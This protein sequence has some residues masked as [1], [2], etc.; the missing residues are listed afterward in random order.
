MAKCIGG[1][2][3]LDGASFSGS[4]SSP[5]FRYLISRKETVL[6]VSLYSEPNSHIL[7]TYYTMHKRTER[8]KER[9]RANRTEGTCLYLTANDYEYPLHTLRPIQHHHFDIAIKFTYNGRLVELNRVPQYVI[10]PWPTQLVQH[11]NT[12]IW[13]CHRTATSIQRSEHDGIDVRRGSR[14][15][16]DWASRYV[17]A[18]IDEN[19]VETKDWGRRTSSR[20]IHRKLH[21]DR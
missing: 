12:H 18:T 7:W 2:D 20:S 5:T 13:S 14:R 19:S 1:M 6:W 10:S 4:S 16:W 11:R 9:E 8:T 3:T 21:A 17:T 15:G